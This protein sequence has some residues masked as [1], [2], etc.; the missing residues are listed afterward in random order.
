MT[1]PLL[2]AKLIFWSYLA[3]IDVE[4]YEGFTLITLLFFQSFRLLAARVYIPNP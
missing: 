3:V 1:K 4:K 2:E